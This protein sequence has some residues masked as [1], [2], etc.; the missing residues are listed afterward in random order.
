MN[1]HG[2]APIKAPQGALERRVWI[3]ARFY[4]N[5]VRHGKVRWKVFLPFF[6]YPAPALTIIFDRFVDHTFGP[7]RLIKD[8]GKHRQ[9]LGFVVDN[10]ALFAGLTVGPGGWRK[11]RKGR[12]V[13]IADDAFAD[14]DHLEPLRLIRICEG[15]T[16]YGDAKAEGA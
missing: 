13:L 3:V 14:F 6:G 5:I 1:E 4:G 12:A 11:G 16:G 2:F 8:R 15:R 10:I 7:V 9:V